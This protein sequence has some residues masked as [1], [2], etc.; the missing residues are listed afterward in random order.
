M[1]SSGGNMDTQP[2][3]LSLDRPLVSFDLETT[4]LDVANDRIVEISCVKLLPDGRREVRTR[5]LNPGRPISPQATAVHGIRDE[6]VAGEPTF[7]Q[8]A[9][10]LHTFF[11]G[12]DLTG[13]NV[14]HFDLPLLTR[15][16][17]RVGLAFPHPGTRVIDSW[18]IFLTKEPR[19]L[20]AACRFYCGR[21]LER[22]HSAEA[23]AMAA[24]DVLLAQ[25]QRYCD[26]PTEVAALEEFCHPM[27][28]DWVD[29]DGRF[30]W[31]DGV[32]CLG[33]GKHRDRPLK[34][35]ARENPDYLRWMCK[36]QFSAE[37]V[38]IAR[39]ALRGVFPERPEDVAALLN[40]GDAKPARPPAAIRAL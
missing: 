27:Q 34:T 23:D 1:K 28:P 10:S 37:A 20:S 35:V 5:R 15:E 16:L 19:D 2:R 38:A 3:A 31:R 9:K 40:D 7:D 22:A 21:E 14:E 13:F 6:D 36:E 8:V 32:I 18:R 39:A 33:F 25:V 24:A 29:R 17:Q 30:V 4:G 26:V 11:E 12:C